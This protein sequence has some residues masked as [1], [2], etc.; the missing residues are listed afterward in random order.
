MRRLIGP[1]ILLLLLS[2]A[3]QASTAS[4]ETAPRLTVIYYYL[5]G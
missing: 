3:V 5:P 4:A 2:A 1:A